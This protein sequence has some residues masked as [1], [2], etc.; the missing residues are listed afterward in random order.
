MVTPIIAFDFNSCCQVSLIDFQSHLDGKFKFM[1]V[2]KNLCNLTK[3]VVLGPLE[4][5][6]TEEVANNIK[7]IFKGT[8]FF[9]SYKLKVANN[10]YIFINIMYY[11]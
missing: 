10:K 3:F 5:K 9:N 6:R 7:D 4:F 11:A 8:S 1:M 2:N